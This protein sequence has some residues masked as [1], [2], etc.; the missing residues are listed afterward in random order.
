[1]KKF[2]RFHARLAL[3]ISTVGG[4]CSFIIVPIGAALKEILTH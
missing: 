3:T 4:Q 2:E 1:M